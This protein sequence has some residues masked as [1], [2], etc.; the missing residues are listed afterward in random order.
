MCVCW[1]VCYIYIN[2]LCWL[3]T[4]PYCL[5][6]PCNKSNVGPQ[7]G[8]LQVLKNI[9]KGKCL[10]IPGVSLSRLAIFPNPKLD[11]VVFR[12]GFIFHHFSAF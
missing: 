10:G 3:G 2:P 9:F 5:R 1:C 8:H 4:S 6:H 11:F 7:N 12:M